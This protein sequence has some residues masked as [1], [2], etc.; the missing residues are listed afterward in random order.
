MASKNV[1]DV[2][3]SVRDA[4]AEQVADLT[5]AL[6]AQGL[7]LH[8]DRATSV[9]LIT[10]GSPADLAAVIAR[11]N[12]LKA[13]YVAHIASTAK[14]IAAD[15]TNTIAAAD[16]TDQA[17][18]N[19]LLNE[20]KTDLNAHHDSATFHDVGAYAGAVGAAPADVAT[21]NAT[22]LATSQALTAA[23]C[24]AFNRHVKSG[25]PVFNRVPS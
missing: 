21:A 13:L 7:L 16:A 18:A 8:R 5:E 4:T 9:Q 11:A 1:P 2:G 19:T 20:I 17:T 22:D 6:R 3:T 25:A 14:H 15:A 23:L 12:A 10:E 24:A